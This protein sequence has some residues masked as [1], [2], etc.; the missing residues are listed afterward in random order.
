MIKQDNAI[1]MC[2]CVSHCQFCAVSCLFIGC[3]MQPVGRVSNVRVLR[4]VFLFW[5]G[6]KLIQEPFTFVTSCDL[7]ISL[8]LDL[9]FLTFPWLVF[10]INQDAESHFLVRSFWLTR[11][12][13]SLCCSVSHYLSHLSGLTSF[14]YCFHIHLFARLMLEKPCASHVGT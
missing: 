11:R 13:M 8:S 14:H 7:S 3:G 12:R 9:L 5:S 4:C 2:K 6:S 1:L 10:G